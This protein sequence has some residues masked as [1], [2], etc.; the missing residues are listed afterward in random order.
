[1]LLNDSCAIQHGIQLSRNV[2]SQYRR[3]EKYATEKVV[4]YFATYVHY[5]YGRSVVP[6]HFFSFRLKHQEQHAI[7]WISIATII[8]NLLKLLA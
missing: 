4:N 8:K 1:M 3:L 2:G 7:C 6:Y 5:N